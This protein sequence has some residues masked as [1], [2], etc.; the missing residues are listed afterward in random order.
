MT[1]GGSGAAPQPDSWSMGDVIGYRR[2]RR[3]ARVVDVLAD[4]GRVGARVQ[5][6][7]L[8]RTLLLVGAYLA[9][10]LGGVA[11]VVTMEN[12]WDEGAV[13]SVVGAIVAFISFIVLRIV[14][15]RWELDI[16]RYQT[17][18]DLI[19]ALRLSAD[20]QVR[21]EVSIASL[22]HP[23]NKTDG[24]G[25]AGKFHD[26]GLKLDGTLANGVAFSYRREED[27]EV[28]FDTHWTTTTT[29][30]RTQHTKVKIK[31]SRWR[32]SD[33]LELRPG[34][35]SPHDASFVAPRQTECRSI[36][37]R[38]DLLAAS[39][40]S[41]WQENAAKATPAAIELFANLHRMWDPSSS[42]VDE[43]TL[44]S[45]EVAH[46][47]DRR[48]LAARRFAFA[49]SAV[50]LLTSLGALVGSGVCYLRAPSK[51][52]VVEESYGE[53]LRARGC[54]LRQGRSYGR[55]GLP[56]SCMSAISN[57]YFSERD[58]HRLALSLLFF[59]L[60]LAA[61]GAVLVLTVR[62]RHRRGEV[63]ARFRP[64]LVACL[65]WMLTIAM[66]AMSFG[67]YGS[68]IARRGSVRSHRVAARAAQER[69]DVGESDRREQLAS[70]ELRRAKSKA[71]AAMVFAV[72]GSLLLLASWVVLGLSLRRRRP[73]APVKPAHT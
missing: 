8:C 54:T 28:W 6:R 10:P 16:L 53:V 27:L 17:C 24:P 31:K 63:T 49:L 51:L 29:G 57:A 20:A 33:S 18:S 12:H 39:V 46:I 71:A 41:G 5:R 32:F 67:F 62:G 21:A 35:G 9:L 4:L 26:V 34:T 68:S 30:G 66:F 7:A 61:S 45:A 58:L 60:V 25:K 43:R 73:L 65:L 13:A 44:A 72:P 50:M 11:F 38:D 14:S 22:E 23:D 15:R 42:V 47:E 3:Q 56:S 55:C 36:M 1:T 19:R 37:T 40:G 70:R 64:L 48:P 2:Y 69:Q 59:G 52:R